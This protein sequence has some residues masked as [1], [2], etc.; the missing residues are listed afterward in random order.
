MGTEALSDAL[1][2]ALYAVALPPGEDDARRAAEY[3]GGAA[4]LAADAV[5][6]HTRGDWDENSLAEHEWQLALLARYAAAQATGETA[7]QQ[8]ISARLKRAEWDLRRGLQPLDSLR[9]RRF[10]IDC[11]ERALP[12]CAGSYTDPEDGPFLRAR[13]E[14]ARSALPDYLEHA[15]LET[16]WRGADHRAVLAYVALSV[17]VACNG[18]GSSGEAYLAADYAAAAAANAGGVQSDADELSEREQQL[19]LLSH[20]AGS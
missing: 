3:A 1:Q 13:L 20:H 2:N 16:T 14:D 15:W 12:L 19:A 11:A 18:E 5:R 9:R 6:Y 8:E 17:D 7:A 4:A 10:A